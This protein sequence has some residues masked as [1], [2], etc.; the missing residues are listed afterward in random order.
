MLVCYL[1]HSARIS[2]SCR[3]CWV[4]LDARAA[5]CSRI[6][7]LFRLLGLG[8]QEPKS[9]QREPRPSV[10]AIVADVC[11]AKAFSYFDATIAAFGHRAASLPTQ[12]LPNRFSVVVGRRQRD[13]ARRIAANVAKSPQLFDNQKT[14]ANQIIVRLPDIQRRDYD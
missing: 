12:S 4:R 9:G 11:L 14:T 1:R 13:E 2:P 10:F 6:T 8:Q 3:S 5:L 7:V